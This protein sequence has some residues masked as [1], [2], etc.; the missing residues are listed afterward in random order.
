MYPDYAIPPRILANL[1]VGLPSL[2]AHTVHQ[3]TELAQSLIAV[4][5]VLSGLTY[6]R[7]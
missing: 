4:I 2:S 7:G 5:R 3:D 6:K 1:T